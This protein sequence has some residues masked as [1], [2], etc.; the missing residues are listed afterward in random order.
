MPIPGGAA[1]E[2]HRSCRPERPPLEK[3]APRRRKT[4]PPGAGRQGRLEEPTYL[5]GGRCTGL[6]RSF[7]HQRAVST[8]TSPWRTLRGARPQRRSVILA[9][10][11]PPGHRADGNTQT[12]RRPE[13]GRGG[14]DATP[15]GTHGKSTMAWDSGTVPRAS[16]PRSRHCS[17]SSDALTAIR[18]PETCTFESFL[19]LAVSRARSFS[20]LP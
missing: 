16:R 15:P 9:R 10:V 8:E 4:H 7:M 1:P 17:S 5:E 6:V 2:G 14:D 12:K 18:A 20:P 11:E 3:F 19:S 13:G